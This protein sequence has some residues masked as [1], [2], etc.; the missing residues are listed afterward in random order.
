MAKIDLPSHSR[1]PGILHGI[2]LAFLIIPFI[3]MWFLRHERAPALFYGGWLVW[4]Q[5]MAFLVVSARELHRQGRI[6]DG[7]PTRLITSGVYR[8]V[9]HPLYFGIMLMYAAVM[10]FAQHRLV[11]LLEFAGMVFLYLL[12]IVEEKQAMARFGNDYR[13]YRETTP[14]F[15]I[16][17]GIFKLLKRKS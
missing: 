3:L 1:L 2:A 9:R 11:F 5:G 13:D 8:L 12:A 10:L 15:N 7:E 14:R 6:N 17:V 16:A 4:A